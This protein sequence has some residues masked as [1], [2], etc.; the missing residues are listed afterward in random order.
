MKLVIL[1]AAL[2]LPAS[3]PG[4]RIAAPEQTVDAPARPSPERFDANN[5]HS[6]RKGCIPIVQQVAGEDR[7][8]RGTRLDQQPPAQLLL[9]V[10]REVNGC[11][12]ATIIRRDIGPTPA[13]PR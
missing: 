13:P 9:A 5:A 6:D 3:A 2:V 11:R 10:D 12:E 7:E 8:Y 4:T 1:A